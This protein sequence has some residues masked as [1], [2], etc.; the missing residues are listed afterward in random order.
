[1]YLRGFDTVLSVKFTYCNA[2]NIHLKIL[3]IL[4]IL[5]LDMYI[6]LTWVTT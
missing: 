5:Y 1:M 6:V 3:Y 4:Y 2:A